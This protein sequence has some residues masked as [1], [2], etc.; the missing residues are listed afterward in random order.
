[1]AGLKIVLPTTFSDPNNEL[2]T[3]RDDAI[4][5]AG[6]ITL[7][8]FAHSANPVVGLPADQTM[9][10]NI[11]WKEAAA[12]HGS[13]SQAD[14]SQQLRRSAL[15]GSSND[16]IERTT[17]GGIHVI[18]GQASATT[19][20]GFYIG[21]D[22]TSVA[23]KLSE[24]IFAHMDDD[25]YYSQW[26]RI[27]RPALTP[28]GSSIEEA[29]VSI[30]NSGA[31]ATANL[32]LM[33]NRTGQTPSPGQTLVAT[34]YEPAVPQGTGPSFRA[35]SESAW[36]NTKPADAGKLMAY[37]MNVG[38]VMQAYGGTTGIRPRSTVLYR[39]YLEN[40]TASGRTHAQVAALDKALFDQAF[41]PGGRF[42][43]DT[44]TDPAGY[45]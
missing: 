41:A 4:L 32:L 42:H 43:G 8:D 36:L 19:N 1:M 23:T 37:L 26:Q 21:K 18:M 27:T 30:H 9:I 3:L 6:S 15:I 20:R 31:A 38:Y 33:M 5:T 45:P 24:Y 11:A 35:V 17:K 10:P 14:W 40:L 7:I 12:A 16:F 29:I 13:G 34:T 25:F 22:S 2:P 39:C 28:A 44:F